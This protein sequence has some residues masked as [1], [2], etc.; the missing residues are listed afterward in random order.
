MSVGPKKAVWA[1]AIPAPAQYSTALGDEFLSFLDRVR[2]DPSSEHTYVF[3][4]P[5]RV[6]IGYFP[7]RKHNTGTHPGYD[8]FEAY[9][10]PILSAIRKKYQQLRSISRTD[11]IGVFVCDAGAELFRITW[12]AQFSKERLAEKA[13]GKFQELSFLALVTAQK[14]TRTL[15]EG[16]CSLFYNDA[17]SLRC[18]GA[19]RPVFRW[20][21]DTIPDPAI[22]LPNLKGTLQ[23]LR[24][25]E[26]ISFFGRV[27][28][29]SRRVTGRE[30]MQIKLS[31]RA[32]LDLLTQRIE[33]ATFM[34]A[35][36]FDRN[37]S[38]YGGGNPFHD[39]SGLTIASA[40]LERCPDEDDDWL[41][42]DF[43]G[44]DPAVGPIRNPVPAA[45]A[46]PQELEADGE[47]ADA[48]H[49]GLPGR[50]MLKA[51]AAGPNFC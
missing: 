8:A 50:R 1:L 46:V 28:A 44:E 34:K 18:P 43:V 5:Y 48:G 15:S 9:E 36:G 17:S 19:I 51:R 6:T 30:E 26:G 35:H 42:L 38:S 37:D 12:S 10:A 2:K 32:L 40:R 24:K 13:F 45:D 41:V 20:L 29:R 25:K 3:P 14:C 47:K 7:G 16:R 22:D 39:L 4:A 31:A 49:G 21:G 23:L 11:P 27:P 33:F